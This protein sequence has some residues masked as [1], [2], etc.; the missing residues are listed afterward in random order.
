MQ[1]I[2]IVA[3][4]VLLG[5]MLLLFLFRDPIRESAYDAL[6]RD[7]FID[8]DTDDFDPGPAI[9]SR[10][11]GVDAVYEGRRLRLIEDL[12]RPNGT[13]LVASRSLDW[14]PFCMRQAI[15]L[16]AHKAAFDE[17]GIGL[18]IIT[19]DA[20]RLQQA[21]ADKHGI[22]IALLSDL[23][24]MTFKTLGILNEQYAPGDHRYGI[25]HPGSI[26]IDRSGVVVG[27]LFLEAYSSRVDAAAT[28]AFARE[29]LTE[30]ER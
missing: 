8:S 22:T 24:A 19:Y 12:A 29:A 18:I 27:K 3:F 5:A 11:P 6:T 21:F 23:D 30:A 10:F 25:P 20:P 15:Q 9:G 4:A 13:V 28:L 14:C 17:A 26:V 2:L 16:Q 7:M 1:R